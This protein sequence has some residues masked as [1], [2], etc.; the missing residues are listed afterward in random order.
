MSAE[1][2]SGAEGL[3]PYDTAVSATTRFLI[4]V[5]AWVAGPWAIARGIG[6]WWAVLP[7]LVV[8]VGLPAIF[9]TPGD[10]KATGIATPGP[11]RI[12]I[13]GFLA[14]VA[15]VGAAVVWPSW[16]FVLVALLVVAMVVSGMARYRWLARGAPVV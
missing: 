14:L 3:S 13:E 11:I 7:A 9:N 12:G 16:A 1:A 4:E 15:M 5:V 8:L 10:K 2:V 6:S